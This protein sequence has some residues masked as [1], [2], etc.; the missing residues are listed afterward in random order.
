MAP[1][2]DLL[3]YIRTDRGRHR[4]SLMAV[5]LS[6]AGQE[7]LGAMNVRTVIANRSNTYIDRG[8]DM[9]SGKCGLVGGDIVWWSEVRERKTRQD[10]NKTRDA[11]FI[12]FVL[13]VCLEA[14]ACH[15]WQTT[16]FASRKAALQKHR[17]L[18]RFVVVRVGGRLGPPLPLHTHRRVDGT[19]DEGSMA[20]RWLHRLRR[21]ADDCIPYREWPRAGC[22][23]KNNA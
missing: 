23:L 11:A 2:S 18:V 20:R 15:G 5:D 7:E 16:S 14:R 6:A 10:K 19:P 17:L 1:S 12:A 8:Y 3:Y 9:G 22:V 13:R 4:V 21:G